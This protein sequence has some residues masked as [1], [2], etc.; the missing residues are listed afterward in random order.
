M[1]HPPAC[2][3]IVDLKRLGWS[4]TGLG[5][6]G[7]SATTLGGGL[8]FKAFCFEECFVELGEAELVAFD[9]AT[10]ADEIRLVHVAAFFDF[11]DEF[12]AGEL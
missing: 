8:Q 7:Q 6:V 4:P 12:R 10:L 11:G 1:H 5:F 9:V 3:Q 2:K